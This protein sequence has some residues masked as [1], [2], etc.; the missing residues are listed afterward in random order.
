MKYKIIIAITLLFLLIGVC[1]AT[2][3]NTNELLEHTTTNENKTIEIKINETNKTYTENNENLTQY[4]D[5]NILTVSD[6][7]SWDGIAK[8]STIADRTFKIS[9]YK[10]VISKTKFANLYTAKNVEDY[11]WWCG[12]YDAFNGQKIGDFSTNEDGVG[13]TFKVATNKYVKQLIGKGYLNH[14][15]KLK[16]FHSKNKA[17]KYKNKNKNKYVMSINKKKGK[18]IV[19]KKYYKKLISKKARVYLIFS[20]G[21]TQYSNPS[22]YTLLATTK[23]ENPGYDIYKG[24]VGKY[25]V[26]SSLMGL[27]TA[28][29][30]SS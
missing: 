7:S 18:W 14:K 24:W 3:N 16:E 26:S 13:Y 11:F 23:Y 20:Y 6:T 22:K 4:S 27:K 9:K 19:Y 12:G 5:N 15:V 29:T 1:S 10:V 30:K 17:L 28:K 25:K 2:E 21:C 8:T